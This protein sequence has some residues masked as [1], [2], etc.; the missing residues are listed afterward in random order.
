MRVK[1]VRRKVTKQETTYSRNEVDTDKMEEDI[2][3]AANEKLESNKP[4]NF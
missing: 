3:K 1:I 2:S 4:M